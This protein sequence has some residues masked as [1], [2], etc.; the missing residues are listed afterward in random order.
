MNRHYRV[1]S[2]GTLFR[3]EKWETDPVR[4][5]DD[6]FWKPLNDNTYA[7]KEQAYAVVDRLEEPLKKWTEVPR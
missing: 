5:W 2:N 3:I 6:G 7:S 4:G 1:T